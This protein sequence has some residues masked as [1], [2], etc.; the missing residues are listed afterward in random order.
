ME[1]VRDIFNQI[2]KS[3]A[4]AAQL[5]DLRKLVESKADC[6]TL[7]KVTGG[8]SQA[9][10]DFESKIGELE[11][12][13]SEQVAAVKAANETLASKADAADIT[14]RPQQCRNTN[15]PACLLHLSHRSKSLLTLQSRR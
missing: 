1:S 9:L 8:S 6:S 14:A 3:Y 5:D 12:L 7:D 10:Q 15:L 4:T 11:Q 13:Y 2:E